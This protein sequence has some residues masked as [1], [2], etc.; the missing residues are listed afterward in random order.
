MST[1]N[2]IQERGVNFIKLPSKDSVLNNLRYL[3]SAMTLV[4]GIFGVIVE[5][6]KI[7]LDISFML[8][9][10]LLS[11]SGVVLALTSHKNIIQPYKNFKNMP[12]FIIVPHIIITVLWGFGWIMGFLILTIIVIQFLKI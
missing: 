10:I 1:R 6:Q 4:I 11:L 9:L 3:L 2:Y 8:F 5:S 12:L 7:N